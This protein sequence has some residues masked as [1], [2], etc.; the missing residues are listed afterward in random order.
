MKAKFS[1]SQR[2]SLLLLLPFLAVLSLSCMEAP[3]NQQAE[4]ST[5]HEPVMVRL[6]GT[7][8]ERLER[9][10]G[11]YLDV[12]LITL[13]YSPTSDNA[14]P[15]NKTSYYFSDNLTKQANGQWIG[16]LNNATP[17]NSPYDFFAEA[18]GN[19][20]ITVFFKGSQSNVSLSGGLNN[21]SLRLSPVPVEGFDPDNVT[22]PVITRVEHSGKYQP[23]QGYAVTIGIRADSGDN[24]TLRL[25]AFANE[26]GPPLFD[27]TTKVVHRP[28]YGVPQ[29][30]NYTLSLPMTVA[31]N[32]ELPPQLTLNIE[33]ENKFGYSTRVVVSASR[34]D[35]IAFNS[36]SF[37]PV[38][39]QFMIGPSAN[40]NNQHGLKSFDFGFEISGMYDASQNQDHQLGINFQYADGTPYNTQFSVSSPSF[41]SM[42]D[43]GTL[44]RYDN[45]TP[46]HH[47]HQFLTS[48]VRGVL[49]KSDNYSGKLV[50]NFQLTNN[51]VDNKSFT[52]PA[53]MM[54][55][56]ETS[57]GSGSPSGPAPMV[58]SFYPANG[59]V[60]E[61]HHQGVNITV[62]FDREMDSSSIHTSNITLRDNNN[63]GVPGLIDYH[64]RVAIFDPSNLLSSGN[65]TITVNT[66]VRSST[67]VYL[68]DPQS[69]SFLISSGGGHQP[70][71]MG[72]ATMLHRD[73]QG[74]YNS[75]G[76]FD[77]FDGTKM[78]SSFDRVVLDN[79]SHDS[80]D[81]FTI[82]NKFRLV[83]NNTIYHD[84]ITVRMQHPNGMNHIIYDNA[85]NGFP[86]W[87]ELE[88]QVHQGNMMGAAIDNI[89]IDFAKVNDG[90]RK[91]CQYIRFGNYWDNSSNARAEAQ[92]LW[93][94]SCP[95]W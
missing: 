6:V 91:Y 33:V 8:G 71:S 70:T 95:I 16:V 78:G 77:F 43:N 25:S 3:S 63:N 73:Q 79:L 68:A 1:L 51:T 2:F 84:N 56:M 88:G 37:A 17:A 55:Q 12:G 58:Q 39:Q 14:D 80:L 81:I 65:Y 67:G 19:D 85:S 94:E 50:L 69:A 82:E 28:G 62:T 29:W 23:N 21:L 92:N 30:D 83:N 7:S 52:I 32:A 9:Y 74:N 75:V 48:L 57:D 41:Q 34:Q 13:Y 18:L 35:E 20:N 89:T 5:D 86:G 72:R 38:V 27:N 11:T 66:G 40:Q 53:N 54:P 44:V 60:L 61:Q 93:D 31:A 42:Y 46:I 26:D 22:I 64:N 4:V 76:V 90:S 59:A 36:I 49:Q 45:G 15:D 47:P 10:K 87:P 24:L